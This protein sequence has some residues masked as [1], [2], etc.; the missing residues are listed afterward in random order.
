MVERAI[1]ALI[2]FGR[3]SPV[4]MRIQAQQELPGNTAHHEKFADRLKRTI[5][6]L[7]GWL[8]GSIR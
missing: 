5:S 1:F 8:E 4:L 7:R 3:P 2:A 6:W